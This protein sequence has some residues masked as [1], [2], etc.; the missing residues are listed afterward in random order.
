MKG[1]VFFDLD[2]TL[3]QGQ[4]QKIMALRL[5]REG[6]ISG[7]TFIPILFWFLLYK[8]GVAPNVSWVMSKAYT[9]LKGQ[10]ASKLNKLLRI[11]VTEEI[12]SQ[13]F[14]EALKKI[15]KY[16]QEGYAVG[17]V[18][19]SIDPLVQILVKKLDLSFGRGTKLEQKDGMFTGRIR[20]KVLYGQEKVVII[21]K[22]ALEKGWDLKKSYAFTDSHSDLPLL[23]IVGHPMI[24]NPDERLK[25]KAQLS[26]WK[27]YH[28][29]IDAHQ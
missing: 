22:L 16:Q 28:W 12:E 20:G 10:E 1:A 23:K 15:R 4:S 8:L 13:I 9:L 24:V 18:S 27:I 2:G 21:R 6:Q 19:T 14:P 5:W 29:F 11:I 26:H 25:R 7:L 3:I 17:I